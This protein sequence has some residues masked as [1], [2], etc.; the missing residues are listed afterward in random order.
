MG[1]ILNNP[2]PTATYKVLYVDPAASLNANFS[3]TSGTATTTL[4]TPLIAPGN[5]LNSNYVL[6]NII[7]TS[8]LYNNNNAEHTYLK[9]ETKDN[10]GAYVTD[11]NVTHLEQTQ[12]LQE[13]KLSTNT[14]QVVHTLTAA[15][16]LNGIK[17]KYTV[18]AT[19][20]APGS[21]SSATITASQVSAF[22]LS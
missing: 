15:E 17:I 3:G 5:Y 18:T 6:I 19:V 8:S 4:E 11:L 14:I 22:S 2:I 7:L 21:S 10:L 9:I 20:D 13:T 1:M 12:G 16:K